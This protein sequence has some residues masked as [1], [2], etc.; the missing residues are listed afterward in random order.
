MTHR[1]TLSRAIALLNIGAIFCLGTGV[2]QCQRGGRASNRASSGQTATTR[3]A[4]SQTSTGTGQ[5]STNQAA[6][7]QGGSCPN[8]AASQTGSASTATQSSASTTTSTQSASTFSAQSSQAASAVSVQRTA[9]NQVVLQWSGNT[10]NVQ[11]VYLGVLDANGRVLAQQAVTQLPVQANLPL[12]A[13][14]KYYG[15][16]IVYSNGVVNT[17]YGLIR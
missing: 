8:G 14:A 6:G 16:Q 10:S 17:G 1:I 12:A 15:V 7:G 11:K 9:S 5:T 3:A 13:S 4:A 2:A